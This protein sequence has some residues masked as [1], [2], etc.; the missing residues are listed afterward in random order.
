[1]I[2]TILVSFAF[3]V[4]TAV[5]VYSQE[6]PKEIRGYKLHREKITIS[7][8]KQTTVSPAYVTVGDPTLVE[9]S[10]SGVTF[11]LPAELLSTEQSG[12]VDFLTFRDVRVNGIAVEVEEYR[13]PFSFKKNA[14]VKLPK[15]ARI[16]LSL[17]SLAQGAWKEMKDSKSEWKVGGRVF[18]FGQFRRY[19]FL[20][21]RVVPIDFELSIPNPVRRIS[22][23]A[24]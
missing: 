7:V 21:K 17:T 18:V 14:K 24:K 16:F 22:D 5:A 20:H 1:M 3:V 15:P 4:I 12:K 2:R 13:N 10:V 23:T 19:G 8:G 11:E 6:F 9:L